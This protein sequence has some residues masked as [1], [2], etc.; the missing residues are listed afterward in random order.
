[1]DIQK[2][3]EYTNESDKSSVNEAKMKIKGE[4]YDLWND[5]EIQSKLKNIN[6][7][8]VGDIDNIMTL[9]GSK[10]E[11]DKI[12]SLFGINEALIGSWEYLNHPGG[13][14]KYLRISGGA[15]LKKAFKKHIGGKFTDVSQL[16]EDFFH[17][18]AY[19]GEELES[20][21]FHNDS[22]ATGW[23]IFKD[24]ESGANIV[25]IRQLGIP[26][27]LYYMSSKDKSK[28]VNESLYPG[29]T[30]AGIQ[31]FEEFLNESTKGVAK[32][33]DIIDDSEAS[34]QEIDNAKKKLNKMTL[35]I[36]NISVVEFVNDHLDGRYKLTVNKG[37]GWKITDPSNNRLIIAGTTDNIKLSDVSLA[38]YMYE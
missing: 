25:N 17:I 20:G 19:K 11:L 8:I 3:E 26:N 27:N 31:Y 21:Q 5:K 30:V 4:P 18:P 7:N 10:E 6:F 15:Q 14:D 32:Y 24:I 16:D 1:M 35:D 34:I 29:G 28:V 2:F 13:F 22:N 23:S 33:L 36:K 37:T 12:K 9:S 38:I